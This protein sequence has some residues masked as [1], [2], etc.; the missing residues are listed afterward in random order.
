MKKEKDDITSFC[1]PGGEREA[2]RSSLMSQNL[3]KNIGGALSWKNESRLY[4]YPY[5]FAMISD[6]LNPPMEVKYHLVPSNTATLK[7]R[8]TISDRC[9]YGLF[10]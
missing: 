7:V 1:H 2:S 8:N 5:S 6:H 10:I 3:S 9:S 4:N